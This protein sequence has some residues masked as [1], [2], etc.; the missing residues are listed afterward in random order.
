[1]GVSSECGDIYRGIFK[2]HLPKV[3]VPNQW[4]E[5]LYQEEN[6]ASRTKLSATNRDFQAFNEWNFYAIHAKNNSHSFLKG[7]FVPMF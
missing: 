2:I 4:Q 6:R 1:M 3:K 5:W 7:N